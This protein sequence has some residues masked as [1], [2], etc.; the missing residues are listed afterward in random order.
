MRSSECKREGE[1][2]GEGLRRWGKEGGARG[3]GRDEYKR[4]LEARDEGN[5][6]GEGQKRKGRRGGEG[7][8]QRKR[9]GDTKG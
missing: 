8:K 3:M 4:E 5:M 1:T 2:R 9:D 7:Q 6:R